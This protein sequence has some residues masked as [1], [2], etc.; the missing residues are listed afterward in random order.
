MARACSRN[1]HREA[2][3]RAPG[4]HARPH[5]GPRP[6]RLVLGLLVVVALVFAATVMPAAVALAEEDDG[7]SDTSS[8]TEGTE[9]TEGEGTAGVDDVGLADDEVGVDPGV[10]TDP[11]ASAP[12][13]SGPVGATPAGA[14]APTQHE[15]TPPGPS[16][17]PTSLPGPPSRTN[18]P[19]VDMLPGLACC[20]T[21]GPGGNTGEHGQHE[22]DE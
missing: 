1:R 13:A 14:V 4:R 5:P 2:L 11:A 18:I 6:L 12:A 22:S 19:G 20:P 21:S 10:S 7:A 17:I 9:G 3:A 8:S 15:V 16:S